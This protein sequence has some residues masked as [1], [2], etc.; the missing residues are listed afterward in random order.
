MI[1]TLLLALPMSLALACGAASAQSSQ[2]AHA[3][4]VLPNQAAQPLK[5]LRYAFPVAESSFDPAQI[6]DL[7]SRTV[8]SGIF[9]APLEFEFLAN[10]ARMRPNTAA[11]MPEV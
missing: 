4:K 6:T 3:P 7:Y 1:R 8:A 2:Q 9:D 5:V 11:E 10:P